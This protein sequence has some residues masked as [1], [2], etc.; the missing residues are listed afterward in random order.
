MPIRKSDIGGG[1]PSGE[2]AER[3]INPEI[4]DQFYNGTIGVLEIY[5]ASGWLPATGE[6]SFN[7]SVTG[8]ETTATL[9]KEYFAGAYSIESAM[10]DSAYDIYVYAPNGSPA[11]YSSGAAL[12][13]SASFNKVVVIGGTAGD[14]LSF[15]YKPTFTSLSSNDEVLAGAV[16]SSIF[17]SSLPSI[18][19][20]TT[21]TGKNFANNLAVYFVG[22]DQTQVSAKSVSV[23]SPTSAIIERPDS[24]PETNDPYTIIVENPGIPQPQGSLLNVLQNAITAGTSPIWQ[25][26]TVPPM[27]INV[28]YSTTVVATDTENTNIDYSIVSGSLPSGLT[29]NSETGVISGT[30]SSTSSAT[31]TIRA[32]DTGGNFVDK[33]FTLFV[34]IYQFT[35]HTFTTAGLIGRSGPSLSQIRS[36]YSSTTWANTYLEQTLSGCQ[37]WTV[38]VNGT[39]RFEVVGAASWNATSTSNNGGRGR[40]IYADMALSAGQK[41]NILVGQTS[42]TGSGGDYE[43]G[44]GGASAVF[45]NISA[46][47][48]A[49]LSDLYVIAGGGGGESQA[50]SAGQD[51]SYSF[52][53]DS[54][55]TTSTGNGGSTNPNNDSYGPGG[56]GGFLT[57]GASKYNSNNNSTVYGGSSFKNGFL[58]GYQSAQGTS[59][60]SQGGFGGGGAVRGDSYAGAGG[61]GG[62]SGG[63]GGDDGVP[64]GGGGSYVTASATNVSDGGVGSYGASGYVTVTLL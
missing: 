40:R 33:Q 41:L 47:S 43:S 48:S 24:L 46:F 5:T 45:A 51:G 49:T 21:L 29:L 25:T 1:I 28:A 34:A 2:S 27:Y 52:V 17:P 9:D 59:G 4:G 37:L 18:G 55:G 26:Q 38:P 39:Y 6:N 3:P 60:N 13:A 23:V 54:T 50:H 63:R 36:A 11:G 56:G 62:Y 19:D 20:T 44:G 64:S 42:N 57:D 61:G 10:I 8:S 58:G 30:S 31:F 22:A 35:S 15:S 32:T 12:V 16:A 53:S 14:L 7:I